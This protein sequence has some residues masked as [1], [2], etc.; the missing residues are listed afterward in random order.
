MGS[1]WAAPVCVSSLRLFSSQKKCFEMKLVWRL[2]LGKHF[3]RVLFLCP[4]VSKSHIFHDLVKLCRVGH[5][6]TCRYQNTNPYLDLH[7]PYPAQV[8]SKTCVGLTCRWQITRGFANPC[9]GDI[10]WASKLSPRTRNRCKR[11]LWIGDTPLMKL[12][13]QL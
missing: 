8:R 3:G 1:S 2:P 10:I 5:G 9:T 7:N 12:W 13:I 4:A 11:G 6:S